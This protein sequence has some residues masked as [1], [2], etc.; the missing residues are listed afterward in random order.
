MYFEDSA[1]FLSVHMFT[2]KKTG[3]K[4]YRTHVYGA[5]WILVFAVFNGFIGSGFIE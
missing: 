5:R 1:D 3:E 2:A 4:N